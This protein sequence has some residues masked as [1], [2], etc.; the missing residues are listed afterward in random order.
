MKFW[1]KLLH[2]LVFVW[3]T[4][5]IIPLFALLITAIGLTYVIY[6]KALAKDLADGIGRIA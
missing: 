5:W 6:G 4:I 1:N 2:I 3:Y